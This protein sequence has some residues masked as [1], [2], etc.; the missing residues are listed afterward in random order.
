MFRYISEKILENRL[1]QQ[2]AEYKIFQCLGWMVKLICTIPTWYPEFIGNYGRLVAKFPKTNL[3]ISLLIALVC[4]LG[5][6][7]RFVYLSNNEQLFVPNDAIGLHVSFMII[8]H[9]SIQLMTQLT[10]FYFF[11]RNAQSLNPI[12]LWISTR[13]MSEVMKVGTPPVLPLLWPQ[14]TL[15]RI[16]SSHTTDS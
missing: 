7:L 9:L 13:S 14:K 8:Y 5:L 16:A 6:P 3:C 12:F 2:V 1:G 4:I 11:C 15:S 10:Y